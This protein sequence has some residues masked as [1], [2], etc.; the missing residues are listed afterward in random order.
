[1]QRIVARP[2]SALLRSLV[3]AFYYHENNLA[4]SLERIVPNGQAHLMVNLCEDQFR[5]YCGVDCES[6]SYAPGAVLA[7][8]RA[9]ATVID[10]QEQRWLVAVEFKPG[11]AA[12]FFKPPMSEMQDQI[13]GLDELWGCSGR[14]LR[15]QLL[16]AT[17]AED[18]FRV[19]ESVLLAQL[20][21]LP[22]PAVR[23]A[24]AK[25]ERGA[26]VGAT[27]AALGLLPR[28]L[29]RRFREQ[30]GLTPKQFARVRRLQRV[31][32]DVCRR[33]RVDWSELAA[34]HGFSDQSHL[35]HEFREIAGLTPTGYR[36]HSPQR[37]NHVPVRDTRDAGV[38]QS[39]TAVRLG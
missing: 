36:P 24:M 14:L 23:C 26:S 11:G 15:E 8:P 12:S 10:T 35:V 19:L 25:L 3:K 32:G 34:H 16:E 4:E 6:V 17:A 1:M 20:V 33:E 28:T 37:R 31:A 38:S 7:G 27:S 9:R 39:S 30:A 21:R 2:R 22:D 29:V 5:S 13:A 18:R